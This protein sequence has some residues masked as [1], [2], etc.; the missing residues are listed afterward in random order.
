VGSA[1][2]AWRL[3]LGR[4]LSWRV[5]RTPKGPPS[6]CRVLVSPVASAAGVGPQVKAAGAW[7]AVGG[8]AIVEPGPP[9]APA[10]DRSGSSGPKG[11]DRDAQGADG[12][13]ACR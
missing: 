6:R 8:A 4:G 2:I 12:P 5:Y 11:E 13:G 9:A 3:H 1:P 7:R 10:A